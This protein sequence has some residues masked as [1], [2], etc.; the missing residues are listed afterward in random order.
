VS[1]DFQALVQQVK[2]LGESAPLREKR[3]QERLQTALT[4][5]QKN[6]T[7]LPLLRQKVQ[8]FVSQVESTLRC[9][10]PVDQPL[11]FRQ[12][13]TKQPILGTLIAADG[14]QINP[15][16]HAA[17]DFCLIN[18]GAITL[19]LG[20]SEAPKTTIRSQLLYDEAL[21]TRSG[22]LTEQMV[23]LMRDLEERKL[24]AELAAKLP[25]PVFTLTDGPL[26][27]WA[28]REGAREAREY[29]QRFEQYLQALKQ[30]HALEA[31][32][33]GYV[34]RPRA[35]LVI[36]LLEI[37]QLPVEQWSSAATMRP[38]RGVTDVNL[39]ARLLAPHERSAVFRIQSPSARLYPDEL[40]LHFFYLNVGRENRPYLA[41]V[42][43]PAWVVHTPGM[44]DQLHALLVHQCQQMGAHPYPYLLHRSHEVA[45]VSRAEKEQLENMIQLEL[46]RCGIRLREKSSKQMAKETATRRGAS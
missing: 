45:R 15:D 12:L 10:V 35:D 20:S 11:T 33:A 32:T 46:R 7:S 9:A 44:L 27:L 36:R 5:L 4:L 8:Q 39:F 30:L 19:Q 17:V 16:R 28:G 23:A 43:I 40:A 13:P 21:Y 34:D 6:A 42:E 22:I 18:A 31:V 1:L 29:Q 24:L 38:L 25:P 3:L 2:Q 37:A 41:R 26:E 14:S